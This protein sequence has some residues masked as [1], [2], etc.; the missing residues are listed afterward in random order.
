VIT[1]KEL[2]KIILILF[3]APILSSLALAAGGSPQQWTITINIYPTAITFP[4]AD[5]D[6]EPVV[7]ANTAVRV[8]IET[9]P[10]NRRWQ[11]FIRAEGNLVSA[12]G[13]VIP[14]NNISWT[15]TPQPPFRDGVLAAG[16]NL[17]LATDGRG[18][19]E[20]EIVFSFKN[21]WDYVAGEYTQVITITASL[22]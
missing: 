1:A 12:S 5:P 3:L 9:W 21:S 20:G 2:I 14:I 19:E 11:I 10:P 18:R 22:L 8:Q 17:V 16:Q 4:P 6:L 15:A 7:A 13:Q